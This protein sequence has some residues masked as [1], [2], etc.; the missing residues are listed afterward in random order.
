VVLITS[1]PSLIFKKKHHAC[2]YHWVG[3]EIAGRIM[4]FLNVPSV[5]NHVDVLSKNLPNNDFRGLVK[6]CWRKRNRRLIVSSFTL[7]VVM[8][9]LLW[10]KYFI[11]Y[12]LR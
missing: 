12:L 6:P 8:I 2:P 7:L 11:C 3:E 5:T 4:N 10:G 1:V 9:W